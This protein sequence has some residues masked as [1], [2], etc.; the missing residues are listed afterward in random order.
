[1]FENDAH[2]TR[3]NFVKGAGAGAA[4]MAL[5]GTD[6]FIAHAASSTDTAR[7]HPI[8]KDVNIVLVHGAFVDGSSWSKVIPLLQSEGFKVL[9]IQNPLTSLQNDVNMTRQALATL[10]GPT[11]LVGHSY[12]GTVITNIDPQ[13]AHVIGL[14]YIAAFAPDAGESVNDLNGK[15]PASPAAAHFVPAYGEGLVWIDPPYFP[16]TFVQDVPA[17]EG[18]ALAQAQKPTALACFK[19]ASGTPTWKSVP[20]WYLVS[21]NDRTI[22]PE[23]ERFMAQRIGATTREVASSHASPVAHPEAVADIILLAASKR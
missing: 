9:A 1:M 19:S 6:A 18:H 7:S 17:R 15:F 4:S 12:G 20:S 11:I 3:R 5:L 2:V 22:Q 13:A 23:T 16:Q 10:R 14:V 21:A 8:N